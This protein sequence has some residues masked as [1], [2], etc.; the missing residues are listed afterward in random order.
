MPQLN[1]GG[2]FVFGLSIIGVQNRIQIPTQALAEYDIT[3]YGKIIIFTG[4]KATGGFCITNHT[5]LSNSK[6]KHILADCPTLSNYELEEGHF[7]QYQGRGYSWLTISPSGII[8]LP[9]HTMDYLHLTINDKLMCIRSSD[10]AFTM[11][12]KGSLMD[13]V[14]AYKGTIPEY[15]ILPN[16]IIN[17]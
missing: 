16:K 17:E 2:K 3:K 11:G 10:I 7:I 12:A 15:K 4:A 1:K 5:L 8:Q 6:L 9:N 13:K 14:Y